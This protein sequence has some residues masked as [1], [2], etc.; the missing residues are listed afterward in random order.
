[1][2]RRS[3]RRWST[4]FKKRVVAEASQPGVSAAAIARRY[5]LND[6]LL[7]NWKKK[8]GC[9][10]ALIPVEIVADQNKV[11]PVQPIGP[12]LTDDGAVDSERPSQI[13][14]DLPCGARLR[15]RS[16]IEPSAL[17]QIISVLRRKP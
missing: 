16:D 7:F 4:E 17:S 6:N 11:V 10:A 2:A 3:R 15:C 13:E 9:E 8:F 14:I 5:D 1:M 12:T